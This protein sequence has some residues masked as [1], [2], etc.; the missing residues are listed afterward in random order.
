M[1]LQ[2][3]KVY[4]KFH[5]RMK[6]NRLHFLVALPCEMAGDSLETVSCS[7]T[8]VEACCADLRSANMEAALHPL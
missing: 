8:T 3:W 4:G 2:D 7:T 6:W 1:T 5:G